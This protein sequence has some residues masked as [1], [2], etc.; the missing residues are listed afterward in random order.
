MSHCFPENEGRK[1][2]R[3]GNKWTLSQ[4]ARYENK[5]EMPIYVK[6]IQICVYVNLHMY[7][8]VCALRT[9]KEPPLRRPQ[10]SIRIERVQWQTTT[11]TTAYDTVC[12][13]L[14]QGQSSLY[15][16]Y[17]SYNWYDLYT[18]AHTHTHTVASKFTCESQYDVI[19]ATKATRNVLKQF[20]LN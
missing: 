18:H 16:R 2:I 20:V 17:Y 5:H 7:M 4:R 15:S 6:R 19:R 1:K 11:T 14:L 9:Y 13:N 8:C 3:K 10:R 12:V